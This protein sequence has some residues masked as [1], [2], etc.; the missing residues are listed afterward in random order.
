MATQTQTS[1][2]YRPRIAVAHLA[3]D[4]VGGGEVVA[5][6]TLAALKDS[7]DVTLI[8]FT[9]PDLEKM[10]AQFG[11]DLSPNELTWRRIPLA[12]EPP[13][14]IPPRF[15]RRGTEMRAF[16]HA[17]AFCRRIASDYDL[18]I[19]TYN[20]MDFGKPSMQYVHYPQMAM[21]FY[22][23][24]DQLVHGERLTQ[25][26]WR[27]VRCY[28]R[29]LEAAVRF[30]VRASRLRWNATLANSD[31]TARICERAYRHRAKTVYPPVLQS[32]HQLPW[33]SREDGF[34]CVG[35]LTPQKRVDL[36]IDILASVRALG[37]EIHLHIVTANVA[38][39]AYMRSIENLVEDNDW[40]RFDWDL[41]RDDLMRLLG[42]HKFGIHAAS[43]EH[44]GISVAEMAKS[45]MI[46][47]V[48]ASGGQIEI[49]NHPKLT[50]DSKENAVQQIVT[51]L[52]D[53]RAQKQLRSH[54]ESQAS[55]F[56]LERFTDEIQS[57]VWENL[58]NLPKRTQSRL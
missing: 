44:F 14:P 23:G 38:D 2:A 37:Y 51:L 29:R 22:P 32:R 11:I 16:L 6:A 31:W 56:S 3:Q 34:V 7:Y 15:S 52:N 46:P 35:R 5:L 45:G 12:K 1:A 48:H 57:V 27:A 50:Y 36:I 4:W 9:H 53:P 54:L 10:R 41:N 24:F 39:P 58:Q 18:F 28:L 19:S 33:D 21:A 8:S 26:R 42:K 43:K 25:S 47:F 20:E 49:V 55:L 13:W 40:L 30:G 17:M